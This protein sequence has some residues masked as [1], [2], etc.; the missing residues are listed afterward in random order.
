MHVCVLVRVSPFLLDP[1][2]HSTESMNWGRYLCTPQALASHSP[3]GEKQKLP[4][5]TGRAFWLHIL[6]VLALLLIIHP[7]PFPTP[8]FLEVI[9]KT[10]IKQPDVSPVSSVIHKTPSTPHSSLMLYE[11]LKLNQGS[12]I[13]LSDFCWIRMNSCVCH[14]VGWKCAWGASG[15]RMHIHQLLV[16]MDLL[17][18]GHLRF[19]S[20]G[21][22]AV[23]AE[24]SCPQHWVLRCWNGRQDKGKGELLRP[25]LCMMDSIPEGDRRGSLSF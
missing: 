2:T 10:N 19:P 1:H 14:I 8:F 20:P 22:P 15:L 9:K 11:K 23:C 17:T 21:T 12:V 16:E 7:L 4:L 18:M 13:K 25:C 24:A 3:I 5:A 6:Q